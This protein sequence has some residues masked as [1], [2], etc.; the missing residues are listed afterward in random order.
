MDKLVELQSRVQ[1]LEY[2]QKLL[3]KMLA[4]P[5]LD[6]YRLVIEKGISEQEVQAFNEI[7]EDLNKKMEKQKAE[8]FIHFHPLFIE[9]LNSLPA[10]LDA[11]EVVQSCLRQHLYET[12][13]LEFNKCLND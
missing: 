6:F 13:F 3:L 12:L 7:C 9:F 1:L 8:G 11:K 4:A 2:H 10:E 5:N